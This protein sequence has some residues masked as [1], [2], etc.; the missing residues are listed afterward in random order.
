MKKKG[1]KGYSDPL[2]QTFRGFHTLP[3]VVVVVKVFVVVVGTSM[4]SL[5]LRD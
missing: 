1:K 2:R 4:S 3:L 5:A